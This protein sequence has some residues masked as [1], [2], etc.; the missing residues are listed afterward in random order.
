M[1]NELRLHFE[2]KQCIYC[3]SSSPSCRGCHY[4]LELQFADIYSCKPKRPP[5]SGNQ[6]DIKALTLTAC[7]NHLAIGL[8][9]RGG[10][11]LFNSVKAI[12]HF[13]ILYDILFHDFDLSILY[14]PIKILQKDNCIDYIS[15]GLKSN[16]WH[17]TAQKI[18]KI[19]FECIVC[20][21]VFWLRY[22]C[23]LTVLIL[24]QWFLSLW[25]KCY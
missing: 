21:L 1:N 17:I 12:A 23:T 11:S 4:A 2:N 22:I 25:R 14:W 10:S 5:P 8:S 9:G 20:P 13:E 16:V 3:N 6:N 15:F 7:G 18:I 19:S 24:L